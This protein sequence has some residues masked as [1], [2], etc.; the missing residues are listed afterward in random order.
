MPA[1]RWLAASV[2]LV[3]LTGLAGCSSIASEPMT[4]VDRQQIRTAV[5]DEMWQPIGASYPEAFR[6]RITVTHTVPDAD[7]PTRIVA[8]LKD[9]GYQAVALPNDY[10]YTST[11]G[12]TYLQ[13]SIDG[14]ICNATWI[15]QSEVERRMT[16]QQRD[17]L[18]RYQKAVVRPC[19]LLSGARSREAPDRFA[20]GSITGQGN[21][22][23]YDVVWAS[24][25]EPRALAYLEQRCPPIPVW[26]DTANIVS[27]RRE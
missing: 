19:L 16:S 17:A 22:N 10:A 21:W 13:Y 1:R 27:G 11:Q 24:G 6:P 8:C 7:W 3:S 23:P 14:Y 5:L 9:R 26:M 4:A 12:Q 25:L 15:K 18:E 20:A 2:A